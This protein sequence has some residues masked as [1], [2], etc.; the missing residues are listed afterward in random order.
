MYD[1]LWKDWL[2]SN[3]KYD[4][5]LLASQLMTD[6]AK[7]GYLEDLTQRVQTDTALQWQDVA[8]FIQKFSATYQGRI[9]AMP[10][11]GDFH[12][13]YY[14][15]DLLEQ[16]KLEPPATWEEYLAI[17]K[18]FHGKDLNG[19]GQPDYGSC[20]D[21]T[22]DV[23]TSAYMF[24]SIVSSFVQSQGTAQ[25]GFFDPETMKPLVNNQAFAKALD[26]SKQE[27]DYGYPRESTNPL[28][29]RKI[30]IAGRCALAVD[31]GDIGTMAIDPATSK[32]IDKV[33]ST[34]IPGTTQVLDRKTG[35]L[36]A[37]DKF[38]CPYA[39]QGVNHAP[40]AASGGWVGLVNAK[41]NS[42]VK[43][44]AYSFLSFMSQPAQSN[45]DVTK[46][47]TGFNPYRISQ[48]NNQEAWIK[49]GMS[50]EAADQYLGGI[51]VSLNNPNMV[52]D[53]RI[54]QN[55]RYQTEVLGTTVIDFLTDKITKEEAIQRIEKGWEKIT[56]QV[57]RESQ[58]KDYLSSL[59]IL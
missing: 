30:F 21:R 53:L 32:V 55:Y 12:M 10:L 22:S 15:K 16:A 49:A 47:E 18:R 50:S 59:G 45:I 23:R 13:A 8:P 46:G 56:N 19:D 34:I 5:G 44:A 40:Y 1:S 26:I 6:F 54:P 38:T 36:V 41:A 51:G 25:G 28:L 31:W 14:R 2:G 4:V 58:R 27:R 48:F 3:S 24:W 33:G 43:E 9:Y 52:L 42:Q 20:I 7:A 37:C 35:K 11:D 17:A 39:I 57:G 29:P